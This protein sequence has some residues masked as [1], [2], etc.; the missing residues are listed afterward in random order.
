MRKNILLGVVASFCLLI[1]SSE[2][3]AAHHYVTSSYTKDYRGAGGVTRTLYVDDSQVSWFGA[4]SDKTGGL[5]KVRV[6]EVWDWEK[7]SPQRQEIA[8]DFYFYKR[9][10]GLAYSLRDNAMVEYI[11]A[12]DLPGKLTKERGNDAGVHCIYPKGTITENGMKF[13]LLRDILINVTDNH[14][15]E[16]YEKAV[17]FIK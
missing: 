9:E 6:I 10:N 5:L 16:I 1:F 7:R 11:L 13:K 14:Y 12:H 17:Q 4:G 15:G 3:Q 2:V 8:D